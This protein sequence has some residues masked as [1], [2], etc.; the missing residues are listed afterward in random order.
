MKAII[1]DYQAA[2][3]VIRTYWGGMLDLGATTFWEDFDIKDANN[4]ARIDE[5]TPDGI[6]DIHGDFGE[7]CYV[8]YRHSLA[9]GWASGPTAWLSQ[10]VLGINVTNGGEEIELDPH[11]GDLEFA[12]GTFPTKYGVF[13]VRHEKN[14]EG[15]IDTSYKAPDGIKVTKK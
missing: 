4:S 1:E 7:F 15:K 11:L 14:S 5:I 12:E 10:Y 8:G 3:D 9:H 2:L 6:F 13:Q